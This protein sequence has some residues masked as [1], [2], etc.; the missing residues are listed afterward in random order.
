MV[1]MVAM[2]ARL[3]VY[4]LPPAAMVVTVAMLTAARPTIGRIT[5][6]MPRMAIPRAAML[7]HR[8]RPVEILAVRRKVVRQRVAARMA[9]LP[10]AAPAQAV[11][12]LQEIRPAAIPTVA[13]IAAVMVAM[14][15]A[16]LGW[17]EQELAVLVV[18]QPVA[19]VTLVLAVAAV[20][21]AM[22]APGF[23]AMRSV[24][25]AAMPLLRRLLPA[26]EM[27]RR[28]RLAVSAVRR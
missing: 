14:A 5:V 2:V 22:L 1:A 15:P 26:A 25:M 20:L 17:E 13:S 11:T 7:R 10:R 16:V 21:V 4:P 28:M 8:Y 23:L 27:P 12:Q 24:A 6:G 19:P 18:P 9:E 3:R